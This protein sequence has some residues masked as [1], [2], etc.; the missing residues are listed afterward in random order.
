MPLPLLLKSSGTPDIAWGVGELTNYGI[1]QT[2]E[3][4]EEEV[5][6][7]ARDKDGKTCIHAIYDINGD[8]TLDVLMKTGATPPAIGE[9]VTWD[10]KKYWCRNRRKTAQNDQ[11]T[12]LRIT[13]SNRPGITL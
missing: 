9:T 13:L 8:C 10:G 3:D 7:D 1:L 4:G 12:R 6:T 5:A 2:S 11:F